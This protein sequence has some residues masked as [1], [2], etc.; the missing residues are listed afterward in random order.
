MLHSLPYEVYVSSGIFETIVSVYICNR[1]SAE[2]SRKLTY[3][4][5]LCW[6]IDTLLAAGHEVTI[7]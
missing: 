1:M 6:R 3:S 5:N 4:A 7:L 2:P